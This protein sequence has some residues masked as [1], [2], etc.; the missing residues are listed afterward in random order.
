M[1]SSVPMQKNLM[2]ANGNGTASRRGS[3]T[4]KEII[5]HKS[6]ILQLLLE[7]CFLHEMV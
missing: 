1:N 7:R 4:C 3:E 6:V 2:I 5:T